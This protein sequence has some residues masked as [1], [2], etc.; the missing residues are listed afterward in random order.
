MIPA[1]EAQ[2][3][4]LGSHVLDQRGIFDASGHLSAR[5]PHDRGAFLIPP[6]AAPSAAR[7]DALLLIDFEGRV[8]SGDG[9]RPLEW[10]LHARI[11]ARRP[12]VTAVVHSH[13]PVSRVFAI[14]D[15]PLAPVSGMATPWFSEPIS[16][17]AEQSSILDPEVGDRVARALSVAPA[18]LLRAHGSVVVGPSIEAAVVR[19]VAIEDC[20]DSL[21]RAAALGH[22]VHPLTPDEI[23][24]WRSTTP[25]G[26]GK[27]WDYLISNT[28]RKN[29]S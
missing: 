21:I 19:A 2:L 23:A 11:Y 26:Y 25:E 8:L 16:V 7:A 1:R 15:H 13:S 14:S 22:P 18:L 17:L 24:A 27:A 10:P 9:E 12:D 6:R 4:T 20:G 28:E 3:I 5:S 29:P